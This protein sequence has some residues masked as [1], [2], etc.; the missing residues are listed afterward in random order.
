MEVDLE[1]E[2]LGGEGFVGRVSRGNPLNV[3]VCL[4][5]PTSRGEQEGIEGVGT[6]GG[7][8]VGC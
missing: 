8:F 4:D 3:D 6:E 2:E 7:A 1:E 5:F